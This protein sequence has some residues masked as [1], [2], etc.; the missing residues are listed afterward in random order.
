M[1]LFQSY[2]YHHYHEHTPK[3]SFDL[4]DKISGVMELPSLACCADRAKWGLAVAP[5]F[6]KLNVQD[7]IAVL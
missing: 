5:G 4:V 1:V 2:K 6:L 3:A 7:T